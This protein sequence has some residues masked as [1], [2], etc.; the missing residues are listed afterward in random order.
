MLSPALWKTQTA[1]KQVL[2]AAA[3][4]GRRARG[5]RGATPSPGSGHPGPEAGWG[6]EGAGGGAAGVGVGTRRPGPLSGLRAVSRPARLLDSAHARAPVSPAA[7]TPDLPGPR[8]RRPEPGPADRRR[9]DTRGG[10]CGGSSSQAAAAALAAAAAEAVEAAAAAARAGRGVRAPGPR[11]GA[12][13]PPSLSRPPGAGAA[14]RP[15]TSHLLPFPS[16]PH[17]PPHV[18]QRR[19]HA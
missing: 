9:G 5:R 10:T 17:R 7:P 11:S 8:G 3:S 16:R 14:L 6:H 19:A 1:P 13:C 2:E 18:L 12:W 15:F 4:R